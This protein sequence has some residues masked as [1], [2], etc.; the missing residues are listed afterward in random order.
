MVNSITASTYQ[1]TSEVCAT[2]TWMFE[3]P[4][5]DIPYAPMRTLMNSV[6]DITLTDIDFKIVLSRRVVGM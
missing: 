3:N 1:F 2:F 4:C 6:L 5:L